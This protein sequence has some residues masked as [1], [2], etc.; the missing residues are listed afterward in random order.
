MLI[1]RMFEANAKPQTSTTFQMAV[2]LLMM[3]MSNFQGS[4]HF[5]S[6]SDDNGWLQQ[7]MSR[8]PQIVTGLTSKTLG[9]SWSAAGWEEVQDYQV[10]L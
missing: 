10:Y 9:D 3:Y 4:C 6:Q 8:R 1:Y 5:I 2:A 7:K